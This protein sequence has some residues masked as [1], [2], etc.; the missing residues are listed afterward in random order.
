[1][2]ALG[3]IEIII[4]IALLIIAVQI[5]RFVVRKWKG[6]KQLENSQPQS[7]LQIFDG[8]VQQLKNIVKVSVAASILLVF[9]GEN[10]GEKLE[11]MFLL[12]PLNL[13]GVS[14]ISTAQETKRRKPIVIFFVLLLGYNVFTLVIVGL[15]VG[16]H[17][18]K[19]DLYN[20]VGLYTG[21]NTQ[22]L[23]RQEVEGLYA[24]VEQ[25]IVF[26]KLIRLPPLTSHT[27]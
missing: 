22:D 18:S 26:V 3:P 14:L 20:S 19:S 2:N 8:E 27:T 10:I 23:I 12:L 24:I 9:I 7:P 25:V 21:I 1:L 13:I 5:S 16:D 11:A 4:L 15:I 17:L 6:R